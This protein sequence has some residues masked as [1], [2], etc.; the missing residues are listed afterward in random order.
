MRLHV[1]KQK[2]IES[3]KKRTM[4]V[5]TIPTMILAGVLFR[6]FFSF[7]SVIR[8]ALLTWGVID[9]F[10][11]NYFYKEEKFFPYQFLRYAR[12]VANMSGVLIPI[13]PVVWNIGDGIYSLWIYR[14]SALPIEHLPRYGR[15]LNGAMLAV[16]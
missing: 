2:K 13:V 9:G 16:F 15:V 4:E 5:L 7:T 1:P 3:L 6:I 8:A 10:A 14:R 12:I 11:S